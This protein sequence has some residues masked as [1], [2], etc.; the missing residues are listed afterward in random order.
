M[1]KYLV[2]VI[3]LFSFTQIFAQETLF[4]VRGGLNLSNFFADEPDDTNL[5]PGFNVGL[6]TK[7]ALVEDMFYLQAELGYTTKGS[8]VEGDLG[9]AS[10][11]LGYIDLPLMASISFANLINLE[12]GMYAAYLVNTSVSGETASGV[13]FSDDISSDNFKKFDYGL[14]GGANIELQ[15]L[16]IGVRYHYGMQNIMDNDVA[17]FLGDDVRNSV[18]QVYV[19][20]SF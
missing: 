9:E 7:T 1:K 16:T 3:V 4:G 13:S 19:A 5:R 18:F 15:P 10:L 12:G 8:K 2:L 17:N 14:V 6:T 11:N 20:L